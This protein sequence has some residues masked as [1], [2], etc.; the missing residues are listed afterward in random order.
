MMVIMIMMVIMM[1]VMMVM[2]LY[3]RVMII[4]EVT[5]IASGGEVQ[6]RIGAP[7]PLRATNADSTGPSSNQMQVSAVPE[8][9][10]STGVYISSMLMRSSLLSYISIS[11]AHTHVDIVAGVCSRVC[12]NDSYQWQWQQ[13][14]LWQLNTSAAVKNTCQQC[15]CLQRRSSSWLCGYAI[16]HSSHR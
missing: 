7:Q 14:V 8:C 5:V 3:R 9:D 13:V 10:S 12:V 1:M 11:L 4:L 2:M 16:Q 6:G 15:T